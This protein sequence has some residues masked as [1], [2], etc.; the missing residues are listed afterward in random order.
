M[1][2]DPASPMFRLNSLQNLKPVDSRHLR[3]QQDDRKRASGN[4][5]GFQQIQGVRAA[6]RQ[7]G[8]MR[9]F[10]SISDKISRFT[11]LLSTTRTFR[12]R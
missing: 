12:S 3:V 2:T 1:M 10:I 8:F 6:V 5:R 11:A 9:Q 7:V 4:L